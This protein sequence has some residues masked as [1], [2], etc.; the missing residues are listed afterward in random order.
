MRRFTNLILVVVFSSFLTLVFYQKLVLGGSGFINFSDGAKFALIARNL[1]F[2][3][4]FVTDFSFWGNS[5][6]NI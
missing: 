5:L 6:F 3:K 2:G 1:V 4:G